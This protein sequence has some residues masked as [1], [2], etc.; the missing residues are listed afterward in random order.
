[1]L[2]RWFP[3]AEWILWKHWAFR[4]HD[5]TWDQNQL[6]DWK[7]Y[8]EYWLLHFFFCSSNSVFKRSTSQEWWGIKVAWVPVCLCYHTDC[9]SHIVMANMFCLDSDS[10]GVGKIANRSGTRLELKI[11]RDW[12]SVLGQIWLLLLLDTPLKNQ[13]GIM[14]YS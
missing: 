9:L 1:M 10:N 8:F 12:W 4:Y 2:Q 11:S 14:C 5:W 3:A 13:L 7:C 6:L